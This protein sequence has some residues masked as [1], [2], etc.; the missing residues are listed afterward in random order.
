MNKQIHSDRVN[1]SFKYHAEI[2][3]ETEKGFAFISAVGT[4]LD[5]FIKDIK[6]RLN[7]TRDRDSR[8]IEALYDPNGEKINITPKVLT[9]LKK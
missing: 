3:Y 1:H 9:M 8:L 4:S 6:E 7:Y 5:D 2:Q